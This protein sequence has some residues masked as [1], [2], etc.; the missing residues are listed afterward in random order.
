V[1]LIASGIGI[2]PMRALL[3]EFATSHPQVTLIYRASTDRDLAFRKELD[4][5]ASR[6]GA[7][8]HYVLGPRLRSRTSWLPESAAGITDAQGLLRFA[9]NLVHGDVY[10]CGSETWMTA[11][12][13]AARAAGV[14]PGQIHLERFSW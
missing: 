1:T 4:D 11:V 12:Q 8:V 2:T 9:P 14:P 13:D 7:V 6:T 3:E 5:I 10:I